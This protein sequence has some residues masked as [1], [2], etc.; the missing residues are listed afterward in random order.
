[1]YAGMLSHNAVERF[2]LFLT[3]IALVAD[4]SERR[5]VLHSTSE[6]GLDVPHVAVVTVEH[7][8]ER[9][10]DDPPSS[11]VMG[12]PLDLVKAAQEPDTTRTAHRVNSRR[13]RDCEVFPSPFVADGVC[14]FVL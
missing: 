3:S 9:A 5:T 11:S 1:M 4:P 8:I 12:Q 2:M 10:L 7:T 6:N 13:E 14:L